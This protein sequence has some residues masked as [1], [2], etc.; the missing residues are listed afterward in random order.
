MCPTGYNMKP[1]S[2]KE[3]TCC[4]VRLFSNRL[5]LRLSSAGD[6]LTQTWPTRGHYHLPNALANRPTHRHTAAGWHPSTYHIYC[7]PALTFVDAPQRQQ[8][9]HICSAEYIPAAAP[10]LPLRTGYCV[11]KLLFTVLDF[12]CST[13][14]QL[15]DWS[16]V[17]INA[18]MWCVL[19]WYQ[20]FR[21]EAADKLVRIQHLLHL[22]RNIP[23]F[24]QW[25]KT[26]KLSCKHNIVLREYC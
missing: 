20:C 3:T 4:W 11:S 14:A 2:C 21:T 16:W 5:L 25:G 23:Y 26:S 13:V 19:A 6:W 12:L 15:H 8:W 1:L 17:G 24:I 10:E 22:P 18:S 7:F 9:C